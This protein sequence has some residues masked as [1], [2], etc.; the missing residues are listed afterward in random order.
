M[1]LIVLTI[2][3]LY[4]QCF[5]DKDKKSRK[6]NL[7]TICAGNP[8]FLLLIILEIVNIMGYYILDKINLSVLLCAY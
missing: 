3:T 5:V 1:K 2:T 7:P 8:A 6:K 4:Q